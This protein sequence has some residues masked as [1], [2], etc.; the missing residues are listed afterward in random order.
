[1]ATPPA[2]FHALL[3]P[4]ILQVLRATGYHATRPAVLDALTDLA[5]RYMLL[6][7]QHTAAHAASNHREAA[8]AAAAAG[9]SAQPDDF[10][11]TDVRLALQEMGALGA[12][13][14]PTAE[15][16]LEDEDT[17]G[18]DEFVAWFAGQRMKELM[19]FGNADGDSDATDYLSAL[20][21]K[22]NQAAGDAKF[23]DTI[24]GRP[25]E[26]SQVLVEGGPV[27]TIDEW[28]A[29]R[30]P[31]LMRCRAE[32]DYGNGVN[33]GGQRPGS[34]G[35]SSSSGLSSVGSEMRDVSGH[36]DAMDLS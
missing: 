25:G 16:W 2:F 19:E 28:I 20:K 24:L 10:T 32:H 4:A 33:G 7:C 15:L 9:V 6:L 21:K 22:H 1:M 36:G 17:R 5:A 26:G 11:L 30:S 31:D 34:S 12:E 35:G 27:T 13:R 29:L 23:Q 14:T 18:V 3:R 8:A